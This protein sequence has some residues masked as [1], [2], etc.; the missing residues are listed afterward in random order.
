MAFLADASGYDPSLPIPIICCDKALGANNDNTRNV[1]G[2]NNDK[3]QSLFERHKVSN[4]KQRQSFLKHQARH[5]RQCW[6][7]AR[8]VFG[9]IVVAL[10]VS[11]VVLYTQGY[12]EPAQRPEQPNLILG[13]PAWVMWGLV[14]PWIATIGV[15]WLFAAFFMKDDEPYVEVPKDMRRSE[16]HSARKT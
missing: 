4:D 2:A 5:V 14:V 15:T 3:R 7:E 10:T 1:R 13:I 9:I 6:L 12:V 16:S 11:S 8:I